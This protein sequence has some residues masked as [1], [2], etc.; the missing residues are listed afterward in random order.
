MIL[1]IID[2]DAHT[3]QFLK[4]YPIFERNDWLTGIV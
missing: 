2:V 4:I 3:Q 1:I